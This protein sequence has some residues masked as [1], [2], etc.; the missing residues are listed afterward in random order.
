M[1]DA[2][3]IEF[4]AEFRGG[5]IGQGGPHM[6][7]FVICA[8]LVT[9]LGMHGVPGRMMEGDVHL[10]GGGGM[11]HV[12]IELDDGRVLDPSADQFNGFRDGDMPAVYL[13]PAKPDLHTAIRSR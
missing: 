2:E 9:L 11:N 12:W 3:I 5:L 10:K 1:T 6:L 13:G 4:A 8:P 7:C